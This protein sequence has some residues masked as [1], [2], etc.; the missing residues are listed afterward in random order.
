VGVIN[1][2]CRNGFVKTK[3][4][5]FFTTKKKRKPEKSKLQNSDIRLTVTA[6]NCC[7]SIK[8]VYVY[9]YALH[10]AINDVAGGIS[11]S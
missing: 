11:E 10:M 5:R 1:Q 3:V 8:V 9:S 2:D 6:E 7:I 4:F